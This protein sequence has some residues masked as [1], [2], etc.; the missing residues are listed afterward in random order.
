MFV[1][2]AIGQS[3]IRFDPELILREEE[4]IVITEVRDQLAAFQRSVDLR[5]G[6]VVVHQR[7]QRRILQTAADLGQEEL[8]LLLAAHVHAELYRMTPAQDREGILNLIV[9]QGRELRQVHR[10]ADA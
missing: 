9:V 3:E 8:E 7:L 4:V 10:Q 1:T 5:D 2:K 6:R